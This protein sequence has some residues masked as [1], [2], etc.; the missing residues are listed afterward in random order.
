MFFLFFF[1]EEIWKPIVDYE[2]LYEVSNFGRVRSLDRIILRKDG[3]TQTHKGR[4]MRQAP[5]TCC[6]YLITDL[7]KNGKRKHVL[8]HILVAKAFFGDYG[9]DLEVN[10]KD[11]NVLNNYIEN[12]EVITHF[13]NIKHSIE[14]GLKDDCGEKHSNAKITNQIAHEMRVRVKNGETQRSVATYYGVSYKLVNRVILNKGYT[15]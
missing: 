14:N 15:K 3:R 4:M 9:K 8:T 12:L 5:S 11:G 10:H 13:E 1:N 2:G 6:H 7:C